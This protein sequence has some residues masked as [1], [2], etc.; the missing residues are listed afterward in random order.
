MLLP[1]LPP[2]VERENFV[3]HEV[4]WLPKKR[5]LFHTVRPRGR[6]GPRVYRASLRVAEHIRVDGCG[7]RVREH[8]GDTVSFSWDRPL[9]VEIDRIGI[10]IRSGGLT[11]SIGEGMRLSDKRG[12]GAYLLARRDQHARSEPK[13]EE[14]HLA[15]RRLLAARRRK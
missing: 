7:L 13:D 12:L 3:D 10:I 8:D 1:E 2:S 6:L 5:Y 11:S 14:G 4:L 9:E 15:L